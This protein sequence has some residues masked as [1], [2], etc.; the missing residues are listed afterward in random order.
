MQK[1]EVC[2]PLNIDVC[3]HVPGAPQVPPWP[4]LA[5]TLPLLYLRF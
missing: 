5:S 1:I 4:L 3:T 2:S